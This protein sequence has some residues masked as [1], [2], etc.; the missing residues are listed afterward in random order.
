MI[1]SLKSNPLKKKEKSFEELIG[2]MEGYQ[3]ILEIFT[4]RTPDL[5][6]FGFNN[7]KE[8]GIK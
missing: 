7:K 5:R 4:S 8:F 6:Q 1:K 3:K 2:I